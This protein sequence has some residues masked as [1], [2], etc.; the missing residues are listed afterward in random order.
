[1]VVMSFAIPE[2]SEPTTYLMAP[3]IAPKI[4]I[5]PPIIGSHLVHHW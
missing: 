1:M 3:K 5:N 2:T 4:R